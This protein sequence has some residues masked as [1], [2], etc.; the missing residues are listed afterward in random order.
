MPTSRNAERPDYGWHRERCRRVR[1]AEC[2]LSYEAIQRRTSC[3]ERKPEHSRSTT[4]TPRWSN[5]TTQSSNAVTTDKYHFRCNDVAR[6]G[7]PGGSQAGSRRPY[8]GAT[9]GLGGCTVKMKTETFPRKELKDLV[10]LNRTD[11]ADH[12]RVGIVA[13]TSLQGHRNAVSG[14]C[15]CGLQLKS[16]RTRKRNT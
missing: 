14:R 4:S 12:L 9:E 13:P 6:I 10:R 5:H 15:A 3:Y 2:A 7:C 16:V 11:L 8:A 1:S